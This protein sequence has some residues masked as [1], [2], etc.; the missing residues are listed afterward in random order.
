M[1]YYENK[2]GKKVEQDK[3]VRT[4]PQVTALCEL[5]S[6]VTTTKK[7]NNKQ[8]RCDVFAGYSRGNPPTLASSAAGRCSVGKTEDNRAKVQKKKKA[9]KK[10]VSKVREGV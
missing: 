2:I 3:E 4:Q 10:R 9:A 8:K 6:M 1:V 5:S 7:D